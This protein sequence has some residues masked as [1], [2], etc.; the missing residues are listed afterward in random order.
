ML[1]IPNNHARG[2]P[3]PGSY[4]A[5]DSSAAANVSAIR[6]AATSGERHQYRK[7][8][9]ARH[10]RGEHRLRQMPAGSPGVAA[11]GLR[12]GLCPRSRHHAFFTWRANRGHP[13]PAVAASGASCQH[14]HVPVYFLGTPC[15]EVPHHSGAVEC[16]YGCV[17]G[18]ARERRI[19][20]PPAFGGGSSRS[21][22]ELEADALGT[23][24]GLNGAPVVR[25]PSAEN[26]EEAAP[27]REGEHNDHVGPLQSNIER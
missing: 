10:A 18:V 23:S 5:S 4:L 17:L 22:Q 19:E 24:G 2:S 6:S 13:L 20:A 15:Q 11:D 21:I 3:R 25:D 27:A 7:R 26:A 16:D 12:V 8:T 14:T 9:R 1:P